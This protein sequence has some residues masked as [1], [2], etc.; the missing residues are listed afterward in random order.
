MKLL[1][2]KK[3]KIN[4]SDLFLFKNF[5]EIT[6]VNTVCRN[7][8]CPNLGECFNK[9]NVTFLILGKYCTRACSFCAIEKKTPENID[10]NEPYKIAKIVQK[11]GIMYVILTSVTRDDLIDGGATHFFN[12]INIIKKNSPSV[13]VEILVP[14]FKGQKKNIDIVLNAKP[15][16]F[17]HNLETVPLLYNNVR[18]GAY[19]K[20][21]IEVL[22]YAKSKGFIVKTGLMLGLGETYSQIFKVIK[23]IS[24]INVDILTIGQYL[25]PTKHNKKNIKE[26]SKK[27]FKLIKNFAKLIGIKYVL[28]GRYVRSSYL[29]SKIFE[30]FNYY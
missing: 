4:I 9:K 2:F 19:Y 21:S 29:A 17:A 13:K 30:N 7:A 11:L 22:K 10:I 25:S 26:Y 12:V 8:K 28:A 16:V 27:E 15:D 6:N 5:F 3:K 14:D 24:K 18:S 1:K 23:D 20:R